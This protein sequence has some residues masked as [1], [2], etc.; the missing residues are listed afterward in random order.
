M[1]KITLDNP[2]DTTP[3]SEIGSNTLLFALKNAQIVGV[4][5]ETCGGW[6]YY[7]ASNKCKFG[8]KEKI[9]LCKILINQ[10]YE[11]VYAE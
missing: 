4:I 11:I 10:G 6:S 2:K 8:D 3:I 1:K 7:E 9:S 5:I